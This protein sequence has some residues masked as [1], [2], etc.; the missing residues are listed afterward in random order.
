MVFLKGTEKPL[1][2][3]FWSL[4]F[5]S[6]HKNFVPRII[7][8]I[9]TNLSEFQSLKI[10]FENQHFVNI[11]DAPYKSIISDIL[12]LAES[13]STILRFIEERHQF[14]NGRVNQALCGVLEDLMQ[15]YRVNIFG[16]IEISLFFFT[17]ISLFSGLIIHLHFRF[18]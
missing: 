15:D 12:T 7:Y 16:F 18:R 8:Y 11:V 6:H 5:V 17:S 13:Y 2:V 4:L 10:N 14:N 9:S 1:E 3:S